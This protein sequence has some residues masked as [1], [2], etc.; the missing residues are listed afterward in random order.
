MLFN[1]RAVDLKGESMEGRVAKGARSSLLQ[2]GDGVGQQTS[3]DVEAY[4]DQAIAQLLLGDFH[5]Q[6]E[7]SK[8]LAKQLAQWG[9]H[10]VPALLRHLKAQSDSDVQWFLVRILSGFDDQRV[11]EALSELL[12]TTSSEPLQAEIT[13]AL[14]SFG[15]SAIAY[16]SR[17]LAETDSSDDTELVP[18]TATDK[19]VNSRRLLAV[20]TLARIRRSR[21]IDPLLSV[22]FDPDPILRETAIEALGSFHDSRITPVLLAAL[23]DEPAICVEAVRAIGRRSDLLDSTDLVTPLAACL[24]SPHETVACESAVALGRLGHPRAIAA[25]GEQLSQPLA[26]P[27]KVATVQALGWL[28][29]SAAIDYLTQAFSYPAPIIMPAVRQALAKAL[30]QTRETSLKALAAQPLVDWLETY[31]STDLTASDL[32]EDNLVDQRQT[33][34]DFGIIQSVLTALTRLGAT[35]SVDGLISTLGHPDVRVRMHALS[36]LKQ[37]APEEAQRRIQ[38]YLHGETL[39]PAAKQY[40]SETLAAW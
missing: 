12:V 4:I 34:A 30:G 22:A 28:N 20:R 3:A 10:S 26:T 6:W 7:Q 8:Q 14:A 2:L 15:E 29:V 13:K 33:L 32:E 21:T 9:D 11:V 18:D 16:L 35:H 31:V 27:V 19:P 25:L 24:Q 17:L 40:V 5:S 23:E 37:I 36:A 1:A 39:S 38:S